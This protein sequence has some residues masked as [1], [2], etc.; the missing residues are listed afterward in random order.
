MIIRLYMIYKKVISM[1]EKRKL[2][3]GWEDW[4]HRRRNTI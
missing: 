1:M 4:E 2:R 3:V